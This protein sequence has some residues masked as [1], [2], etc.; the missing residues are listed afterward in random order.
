MPTTPA[1]FP[2]PVSSDTITCRYIQTTS[3]PILDM[4]KMPL[5]YCGCSDAKLTCV[6]QVKISRHEGNVRSREFGPQHGLFELAEESRPIR[7]FLLVAE[8]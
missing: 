6:V 1:V 5:A 4:E 7:R 3:F 2:G 8:Q